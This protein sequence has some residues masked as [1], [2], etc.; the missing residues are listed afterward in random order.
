MIRV[1]VYACVFLA[2]VNNFQRQEYTQ[3]V[4]FA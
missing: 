2:I 1:L 4:S 3:F